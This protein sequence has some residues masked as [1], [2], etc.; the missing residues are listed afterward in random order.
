LKATSTT[1]VGRALRAKKL[2]SRF[3][4]HFQIIKHVGPVAY[5]LALPHNLSNL[6]DVFHVSQLRKYIPDPS[7]V[8][9]PK[10]VK[11]GDDL[12]Y[13]AKPIEIVDHSLKTLRNKTIPLVNVIWQS[14]NSTEATWE[15]EQKMRESRIQSCL[16][17]GKFNFEGKIKFKGR[18]I[19]TSQLIKW[20][21]L[22][23]STKY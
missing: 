7:H 6:Y 23:L 22:K 12:F 16:R 3:I 21:M 18:R 13:Q 20:Y 2:H 17:I 8:L 11:L 15:K 19:V 1:G 5:Q 4:G 14:L 10:T 9:R